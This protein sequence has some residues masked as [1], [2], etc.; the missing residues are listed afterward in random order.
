[1]I[2]YYLTENHLT[3]RD[4]DYTAQVQSA[5]SFDKDAL[6]DRM[7]GRGTLL[8]KTDILAVLNSFDETV[9]DILKEGSTI[10]LPLFN[11]A[12]SISG[13]FEGATDSFDPNRHDI[14]INLSRGTLLRELNTDLRVEK[15]ST[16]VA[17][18]NI[19]EVKD[20]VT[21]KVNETITSGGVLEIYGS[22]LKIAGDSSEVGV[23]FVATD[24]GSTKVSTIVQNKPSSLI[25]LVPKLDSGDYNIK[26]VT[27][28]AGGKDL[29][30][31]RSIIFDH[32]LTV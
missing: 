16:P 10:N 22:G 29:K 18:N 23:Y 3:K 15:V 1:M 14:N 13:V 20:S 2:K 26:I 32:I 31:P 28:Y 9:C 7:L 27:Q 5:S 12:F 11:T 21:G 19:I 6:V 4:E 30:E 17:S 24:G 25:V 8:T